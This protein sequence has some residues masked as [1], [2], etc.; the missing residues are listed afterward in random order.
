M[1]CHRPEFVSADLEVISETALCQAEG[2]LETRLLQG[3]Y[4]RG[5]SY[6]DVSAGF[7]HWLPLRFGV[8]REIVIVTLRSEPKR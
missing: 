2:L 5:D 1:W 4:Q 7:G 6:L 3:L 8:P